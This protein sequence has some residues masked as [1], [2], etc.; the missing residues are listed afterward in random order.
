MVDFYFDK[1]GFEEQFTQA[2]NSYMRDN[3]LCI[4]STG[5]IACLESETNPP[6]YIG[7]HFH[8]LKSVIQLGNILDNK[9]SWHTLNVPLAHCKPLVKF[10]HSQI[11]KNLHE[12]FYQ[13]ISKI[14]APDHVCE[15]LKSMHPNY[16]EN[17]LINKKS[18]NSKGWLNDN[19]FDYVKVIFEQ[20]NEEEKKDLLLLILKRNKLPSASFNLQKT[21]YDFVNN[22]ISN[23]YHHYFGSIYENFKKDLED[24]H[25]IF[26]EPKNTFIL[27]INKAGIYQNY[28]L[29][30][31]NKVYPNSYDEMLKSLCLVLCH[32]VTKELNIEDVSLEQKK[33]KYKNWRLVIDY[34]GQSNIEEEKNK[35]ITFLPYYFQAYSTKAKTMKVQ[36]TKENSLECAQKALLLVNLEKDLPQKP[37]N[38][39]FTK[40][41][42]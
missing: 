22:N 2:I 1:L 24:A 6:I 39:V 33:Q 31:D 38:N 42:I 3:G 12:G 27:D 5:T 25:I 37:K 8:K 41:K 28:S 26:S 20:K 29:S 4:Y 16:L 40:N 15:V 18:D 9:N 13:T 17:F 19:F 36:P 30:T 34:N 11:N 35:L 10:L 7:N 32:R 23:S 21:L 14:V